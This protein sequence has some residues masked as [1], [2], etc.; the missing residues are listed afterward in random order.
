MPDFSGD[1]RTTKQAAE[2]GPWGGSETVRNFMLQLAYG[3]AEREVEVRLAKAK[4]P[5]PPHGPLLTQLTA[6]K[7]GVLKMKWDKTIP[8]YVNDPKSGNFAYFA[9]NFCSDVGQG[10]LFELEPKAFQHGH[11]LV[12]APGAK[13]DPTMEIMEKP[14]SYDGAGKWVK[15]ITNAFIRAMVKK[16][17]VSFYNYDNHGSWGLQGKGY[18]LDIFIVDS[19]PDAPTG[20]YPRE[21]AMQ[22]IHNVASAA[23]AVG[24]DWQICYNDVSIAKA[25]AASKYGARVTYSGVSD[26]S[27]PS[28]WHGP[29]NLHLHLDIV[30]TTKKEE[31]VSSP[32][33]AKPPSE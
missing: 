14:S 19:F 17:A 25:V 4:E 7:M 26:T 20:F 2:A 31:G 24:G 3:W 8:A 21:I 1:K 33:G 32:V 10:L 12:I 29:L 15:P 9:R 11:D 28:N 5:K 6:G 16:P 13:E 22:V 27:K 18:S 30:P 23:D